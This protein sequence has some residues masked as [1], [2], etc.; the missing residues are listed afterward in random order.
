[1]NYDGGV[2]GTSWFSKKVLRAE[3]GLELFLFQVGSAYGGH[4]KIGC[5]GGEGI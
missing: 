5:E 2:G 4:T 3:G 1:M